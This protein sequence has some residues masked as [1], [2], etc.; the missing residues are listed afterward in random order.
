MIDFN[1]NFRMAWLRS[2]LSQFGLNPVEWNLI[3]EIGPRK[4]Q[5]Y[6]FRIRHNVDS[7]IEFIGSAHIKKNRVYWKEITHKETA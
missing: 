3:L 1:W 5:I 4:R 7:S 2:Q 6:K